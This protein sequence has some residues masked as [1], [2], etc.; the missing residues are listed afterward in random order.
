MIFNYGTLA[1]LWCRAVEYTAYLYNQGQL[2]AN[3]LK[4]ETGSLMLGEAR[5]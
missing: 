5:S 1:V 4:I 3:D 2:T